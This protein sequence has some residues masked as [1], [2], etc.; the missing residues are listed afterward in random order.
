MASCSCL[1][2]REYGCSVRTCVLPRALLRAASAALCKLH[3]RM[4]SSQ[5]VPP[6]RT[7]LDPR[8]AR[9]L[10][11]FRTI[12]L[13][14][15]KESYATEPERSITGAGLCPVR[16][17]R[18]TV[19]RDTSHLRIQVLIRC[20]GPQHGIGALLAACDHLRISYM[21]LSKT[22]RHLF[23]LA[24]QQHTENYSCSYSVAPNLNS[25]THNH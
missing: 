5:R 11:S 18:R 6:V 21:R 23:K 25:Q 17:A 24:R 8:I 1:T 13:V 14:Q 9:S 16:I 4:G 2:W 7:D 15:N 12:G 20:E 10:L 3:W 19:L 22:Q